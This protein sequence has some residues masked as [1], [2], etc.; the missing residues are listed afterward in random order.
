MDKMEIL[1]VMEEWQRRRH[2]AGADAYDWTVFR[3]YL[4]QNYSR[5]P[6]VAPVAVFL[7]YEPEDREGKHATMNQKTEAA[8]TAAAALEKS[9][10][11]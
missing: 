2:Q 10:S 9:A 1:A 6:G 11:E 4:L 3:G 5:D 7:A 8:L